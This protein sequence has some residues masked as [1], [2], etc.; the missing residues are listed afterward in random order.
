[1]NHKFSRRDFLKLMPIAAGAGLASA[2]ATQVASCPT[3]MPPPSPY[4]LTCSTPIPTPTP[5]PTPIPP[6]TP[7]SAK[8]DVC[9]FYC[10]FRDYVPSG[11]RV[12]PGLETI[13]PLYGDRQDPDTMKMD[14]KWAREFGIGT[15][16]IPAFSSMDP[17]LDDWFLPASEPP[18]DINYALMYNPDDQGWDPAKYRLDIQIEN[19]KEFFVRH[20]QHPRY[21][22]L[23]DSRP[24]VFYYQAQT[25]A[26]F[27]G[28]DKLEQTV[29][30][31]RESFPEEIFLVGD[32]MIAPLQ[33]TNDSNSL[34]QSDY[35][36]RQVKLFDGITS[37]Y[38]VNAGYVWHSDYEWNH[39]VASFQDMIKGFQES[40]DFW[41]DKAHKYGSKLVPAPMPTGVSNRLLYEAGLDSFLWDRHEGVAYD[42]S[43]AMAE[44]GAKYADP[45]LKMV[46]ISNW[47]E[48]SEGAAIVPSVGY[49]FNPAHAVRDTF[50]IEPTGG[51][52]EDYY[53]PS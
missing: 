49:K 20:A 50:A 47:N 12:M 42:T 22:R 44:L 29:A 5:T 52:P 39:V 17:R 9:S 37:Y 30:I 10:H 23:P 48:L 38:I 19:M 26:Y 40:F 31:L 35:V 24:I 43:K 53:P 8:L 7:V 21:K 34:H 6:P 32:V 16:V 4:P 28:I 13:T 15:F 3:P 18:F 11:P 41:S 51:W 45:D 33:V 36:Q 27:F 2:C 25:V 1:M 14:I 46:M